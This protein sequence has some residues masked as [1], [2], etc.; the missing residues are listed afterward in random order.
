[1]TV[2]ELNVLYMCIILQIVYV[3][4]LVSSTYLEIN[5]RTHNI[6]IHPECNDTRIVCSG[7]LSGTSIRGITC[8][9]R[10]G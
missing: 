8:I 9:S 6:D 1:M 5:G 10:H 4:Y 3:L 2:R 7:E